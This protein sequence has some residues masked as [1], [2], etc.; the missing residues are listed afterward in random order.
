MEMDDAYRRKER[1]QLRGFAVI[2]LAAVISLAAAIGF[3]VAGN[4]LKSNNYEEYLSEALSASTQ[5]GAV[6]FYEQAIKL[7]PGRLDA[8][9]ALLDKLLEDD[10][11]VEE[12][13]YELREIL[14]YKVS[15]SQ[16]CE[17]VLAEDKEAYDEFCYQ[18]GVA[19]FYFYEEG[20]NKNNS[21]KWLK[22]ASESKSLEANKVQRA[23]RLLKIAEYYLKIGVQSKS[24]DESTSYR[25]Y[26]A[27]LAELSEGNLVEMDNEVTALMMY[28]EIA[29]QV[30]TNA[31]KFADA[32]VTEEEMAA[33]LEDISAHIESDIK[34]DEQNKDRI[35]ELKK[36][37][38][39]NMKVAQRELETNVSVP[40]EGEEE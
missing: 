20:G 11:F 26:W 30:A 5:E 33:K 37:V 29:Y 1:R 12:E 6:A 10:N 40:V 21:K 25:D 36:N 31:Q 17:D 14:Q 34:A 22:I 23:E 7:E 2:M 18:L 15:N 16:S 27:D 19:Y 39:H 3:H 13:A 28:N 38:M 8:Y 24:G 4:S 9:M 32:G 35:E